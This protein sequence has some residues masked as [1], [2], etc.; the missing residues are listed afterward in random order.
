MASTQGLWNRFGTLSQELTALIISAL[1][2]AWA[3]IAAAATAATPRYGISNSNSSRERLTFSA[4]CSDVSSGLY[5]SASST[6]QQPNAKG[7][8][9]VS[10]T[11]PKAPSPWA[12]SQVHPQAKR[13]LQNLVAAALGYQA[14]QVLLQLT[15]QSG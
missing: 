13:C 12:A 3:A 1:I 5:L 2:K 7:A 11:A 9:H 6:L 10:N 15:C 4:L 8:C 14:V